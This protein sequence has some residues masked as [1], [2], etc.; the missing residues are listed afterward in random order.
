MIGGLSEHKTDFLKHVKIVQ[1]CSLL[2]KAILDFILNANTLQ[3]LLKYAIYRT[4][5][6]ILAYNSMYVIRVCYNVF[7]DPY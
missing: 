5:I 1:E 7:V 2:P 3:Q 4:I 6:I